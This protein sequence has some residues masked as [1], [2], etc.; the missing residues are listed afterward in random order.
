MGHNLIIMHS[1]KIKKEEILKLYKKTAFPEIS[2][3]K[4]QIELLKDLL[5][6]EI[7]EEPLENLFKFQFTPQFKKQKLYSS[8]MKDYN[9]ENP[10]FKQPRSSSTFKPNSN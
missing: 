10:N 6:N 2:L 3:P 4:K 8:F 5:F 9:S 1:I 7:S